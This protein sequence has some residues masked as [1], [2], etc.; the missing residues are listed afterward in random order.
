MY[1]FSNYNYLK[2]KI[3]FYL[4]KDFSFSSLALLTEANNNSLCFLQLYVVF[5]IIKYYKSR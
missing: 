1:R 4:E 3:D 2:N 5:R